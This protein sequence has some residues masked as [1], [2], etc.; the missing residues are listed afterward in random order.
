MFLVS[1]C[2]CSYLQGQG[3]WIED[4]WLRKVDL[5]AQVQQLQE[6]LNCLSHSMAFQDADL[7]GS[8]FQP[9]TLTYLSENSSSSSSCGKAAADL[10]LP[11]D[12]LNNDK[13]TWDLTDVIKNQDSSIIDEMPN[14]PTQEKIKPKD[15]SL[16]LQTSVHSDSLRVEEA[17]PP[18]DPETVQDLSSWSSPEVLR[19][20]SSLEP[21]TR[22]PLTPCSGAMSLCSAEGSPQHTISWLLQ[23]SLGRS[24]GE[25]TPLWTATPSSDHQPV[26]RM[27]AVSTPAVSRQV[28]RRDVS[29]QLP[30][31]AHGILAP[32]G[33]ELQDGA[34]EPWLLQGF[35]HVSYA[36]LV[37]AA[38]GS[39]TATA[40][41]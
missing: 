9:S 15:V 35:Q 12:T 10:L 33:R 41:S 39:F 3:K 4:C 34:T 8:R 20:D 38:K 7:V 32:P 36:G 40:Q 26:E 27:A 25:Q 14:S 37:E 28:A 30:L 22:I 5:I 17:K 1:L 23:S 18:K 2:P 19:K 11:V 6:K 16:S 24:I 21:C 31:L 13:T 29:Q